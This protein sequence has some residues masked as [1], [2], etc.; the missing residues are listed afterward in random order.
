[1][2]ACLSAALNQATMLEAEKGEEIL[3]LKKNPL[4]FVSFFHGQFQDL[5]RKFLAFDEFSRV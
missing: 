3:C 4:E 1:E 5:V 2:M